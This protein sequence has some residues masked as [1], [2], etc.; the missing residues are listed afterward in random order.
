MALYDE[1]VRCELD[2]PIFVSKQEIERTILSLVTKGILEDKLGLL[3]DKELYYVIE[4]G[5]NKSVRN[6]RVLKYAQKDLIEKMKHA[7]DI[8]YKEIFF[9]K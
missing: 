2:N 6:K 9:P 1:V 4:F 8:L 3:N 5:G 7:Q